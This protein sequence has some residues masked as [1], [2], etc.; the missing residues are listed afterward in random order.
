MF[1]QFGHNDQKANDPKRF[2]AP[3]T[4]YRRY[5]EKFVCESREKEAAPVV[6][7]SIVR[8]NFNEFGTLIDTHGGYPMTM[9]M[10]ANEMNVSFVDLQWETEQL[11]QHAGPEGS[12]AMFLWIAA[13]SSE[14]FPEGKQD[15]THL[16]EKGAT[17]IA[18]LA[19]NALRA[20][21]H[22]LSKYMIEQPD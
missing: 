13:G 3:H 15:I 2:T 9:R 20:M 12:K 11:V 7:S 19:V 5:L 1:I 18:R 16:S 22:A 8:R 10:V 6:F 21:N 14:K 17:E 4:G